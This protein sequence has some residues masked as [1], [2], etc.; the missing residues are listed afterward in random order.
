MSNDYEELDMN[1]DLVK[2]EVDS[3]DYGRNHYKSTPF[4]LAKEE[5][6]SELAEITSQRHFG[7]RCSGRRACS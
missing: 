7:G 4:T 1:N 3:W 2:I 6:F 5:G